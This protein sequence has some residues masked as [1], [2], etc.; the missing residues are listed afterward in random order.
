M[1]EDGLVRSRVKRQ[2]I[3]KSG[4]KCFVISIFVL[5]FEFCT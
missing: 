3:D 1:E 5:S 4:A 2:K